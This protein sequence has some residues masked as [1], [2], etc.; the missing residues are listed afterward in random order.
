[1]FAGGLGVNFSRNVGHGVNIACKV[2]GHGANFSL[3]MPKNRVLGLLAGAIFAQLRK[4]TI[5]DRPPKRQFIG[6]GVNMSVSH[7]A[8]IASSNNT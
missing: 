1:M 2:V 5:K 3:T 7:G 6:D 8:N 4:V